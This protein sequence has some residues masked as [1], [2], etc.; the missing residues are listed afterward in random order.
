MPPG[1]QIAIKDRLA[2]LVIGFGLADSRAYCMTRLLSF[3][4]GFPGIAGLGS[5]SQVSVD[6]CVFALVAGGTFIDGESETVF[7]LFGV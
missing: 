7:P 4:S 1:K 2:R 6:V 3:G 5:P